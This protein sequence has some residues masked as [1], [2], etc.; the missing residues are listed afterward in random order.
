MKY[1]D[2][3][4]E[5][6]SQKLFDSLPEYSCSTPTLQTIGKVWKCNLNFGTNQL[7]KWIICEY[8]KSN[9]VG[10]VGLNYRRPEIK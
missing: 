5:Q 9:E 7:P 4:F 8:V 6:I 3:P 10:F 2:M 1:E